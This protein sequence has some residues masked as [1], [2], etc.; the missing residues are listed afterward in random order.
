MV[1]QITLGNAGDRLQY[2]TELNDRPFGNQEVQ[3]SVVCFLVQPHSRQV[4]YLYPIGNTGV[5]RNLVS[6][7][8]N[9]NLQPTDLKVNGLCLFSSERLFLKR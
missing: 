9:A 6:K 5:T 3:V 2:R 7:R 8:L 4:D 1:R